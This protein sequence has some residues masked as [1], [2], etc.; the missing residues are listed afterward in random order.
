MVYVHEFNFAI[1]S[2]G[3]LI[4]VYAEHIHS[5]AGGMHRRERDINKTFKGLE[6]IAKE[7]K[8]NKNR[9][10]SHFDTIIT[11]DSRFKARKKGSKPTGGDVLFSMTDLV[12]LVQGYKAYKEGEFWVACQVKRKELKAAL[13]HISDAYLEGPDPDEEEESE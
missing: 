4:V 2:F 9:F 7:L 3:T 6:T 8:V 12:K 13:K 10:R 1:G 11:K 5:G